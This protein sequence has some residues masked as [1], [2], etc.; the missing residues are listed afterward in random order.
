[1]TAPQ[2]FIECQFI[3]VGNLVVRVVEDA[4][5]PSRKHCQNKNPEQLPQHRHL[6]A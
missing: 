1:M 4:H 3:L 2:W 6:M 5:E